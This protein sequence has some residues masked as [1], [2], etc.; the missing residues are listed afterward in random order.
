MKTTM[1]T[2]SGAVIGATVAAVVFRRYLPRTPGLNRMLLEPPS[3]A[4]LEHIT[5]REAL[6][7][8]SNLMGQVGAATTPL[9]PAGKARFGGRL[10]DVI[11]RGEAIDRGTQVIVVEVRGNRVLVQ[12]APPP[13]ATT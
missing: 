1:M 8:F 10:I 12:T 11:A 4:E 5:T 9:M 6:V 2:I 3:G 7:D 13:S